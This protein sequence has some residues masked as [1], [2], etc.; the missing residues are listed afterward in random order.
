MKFER[1][2]RFN[3]KWFLMNPKDK[4][5]SILAKKTDIPLIGLLRLTSSKQDTIGEEND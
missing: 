4:I 3:V 1:Y 5:N 2:Y